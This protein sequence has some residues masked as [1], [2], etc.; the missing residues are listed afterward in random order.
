M[1]YL[2]FLFIAFFLLLSCQAEKK[3]DVQENI[4]KARS[5]VKEFGG[6]LKPILVSHFKNDGPVAAI[7]V[8]SKS[9]PEIA[10]NLSEKSGWEIKRVSQKPRNVKTGTA[11]DRKSV[12]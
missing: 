4:Q 11:E 2:F 5:L 10:Q 6:T 3:A 1:K 8:C 9:A 12:V 7:E